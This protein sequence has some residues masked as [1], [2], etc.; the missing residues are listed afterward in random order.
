MFL[1][2]EARFPRASPFK[3]V[4]FTK[5]TA[6]G[7]GCQIGWQPRSLLTQKCRFVPSASHCAA[8]QS[9]VLAIVIARSRADNV[10]EQAIKRRQS[11]LP[12]QAGNRQL[13]R[14]LWHKATWNK[15]SMKSRS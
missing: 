13:R 15:S 1:I 11:K 2:T 8:A 12:M 10:R 9:L 3:L 4:I 5:A 14:S 7:S 6:E